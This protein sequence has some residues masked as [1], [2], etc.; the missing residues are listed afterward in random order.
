VTPPRWFERLL[1]LRQPA[2]AFAALALAVAA[3][4]ALALAVWV[5]SGFVAFHADAAPALAIPAVFGAGL[6]LFSFAKRLRGGQS[7]PA[8]SVITS[9][10]TAFAIAGLVWPLSF[11]LAIA[12]QGDFSGALSHTPPA[13]AGLAVG[14]G[15]GA[16]GGALAS[17]IAF[18]PT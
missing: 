12:L 13:L 1:V 15:G 6:A 7:M 5:S 17:L 11:A 18:K 9:A 3:M 2:V 4:T 16:V 10:A 14:A 8:R